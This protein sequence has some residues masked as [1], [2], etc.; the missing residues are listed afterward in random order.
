MKIDILLIQNP[1]LAL[2]RGVGSFLGYRV[3][4]ASDPTPL[5]TIMVHVSLALSVVDLEGD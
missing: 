3:Y 4:V 1:P 2:V 5:A